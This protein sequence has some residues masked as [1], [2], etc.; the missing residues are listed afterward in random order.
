MSAS[1]KGAAA[2]HH[3]G[4]RGALQPLVDLLHFLLALG[5]LDEDDVGAGLAVGHG[6]VQRLG[7]AVAGACIGARDDHHVVI[8]AGVH[9]GLDPALHFGDVDQLAS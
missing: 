6:A 8:V 3:V 1:R 7:Q 5:R 4:E 9:G 2:F